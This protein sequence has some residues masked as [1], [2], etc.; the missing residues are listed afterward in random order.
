[1]KLQKLD[2]AW[3]R[4]NGNGALYK[5]TSTGINQGIFFEDAHNSNGRYYVIATPPGDGAHIERYTL[6]GLVRAGFAY[7][8]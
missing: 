4:V 8:S 3:A 5:L 7:V 2:N 1:M 6:D